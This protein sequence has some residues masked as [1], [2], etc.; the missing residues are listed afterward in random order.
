MNFASPT[1]SVSSCPGLV[2]AV[3]THLNRAIPLHV[4]DLQTTWNEFSGHFAADILLYAIRQFLFAKGHSTL[5]VKKST[6]SVKNAANF[7]KSQRL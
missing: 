2:E 5:I 4:I 3:N 1:G 7:C 6:S